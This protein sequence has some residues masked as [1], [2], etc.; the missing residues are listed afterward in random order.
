MPA[1]RTTVPEASSVSGLADIQAKLAEL[2]KRMATNVVR[3]GL[4]AGG[5]VI[6]D[7]ARVRVPVR[8]GAL[9][10][11]IISRTN[12]SV[13]VPNEY[14][15]EVTIDRKVF[16]FVTT[17]S[18]RSKLKGTKL[19][20]GQ[21][22]GN[23]KGKIYPKNYAHLVE[24]GT[25]P[26][27]IRAKRGKF[28]GLPVGARKVVMHP[29]ARPKPFLRPALAAKRFVAIEAIKNKMLAEAIKELAK[30]AATKRR[31]A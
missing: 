30:I 21:I 12:N 19:A 15:V 2:P 13:K 10:K 7:E 26:H 11:S 17:K 25:K 27:E 23:I 6:R 8:F 4:L 5:G 20:K 3:R 14:R 28:L 29:G 22:K 24:F 31:S 1:A 9:K 18:G 16:E